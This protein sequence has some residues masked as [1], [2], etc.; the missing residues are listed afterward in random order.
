MWSIHRRAESLVTIT[1]YSYTQGAIT[2]T[3]PLL[4]QETLRRQL[5]NMLMHS[6]NEVSQAVAGAYL[7]TGSTASENG[8]CYRPNCFW[9]TPLAPVKPSSGGCLVDVSEGFVLLRNFLNLG[10]DEDGTTLEPLGVSC[11]P[12]RMC[13]RKVRDSKNPIAA[14]VVLQSILAELEW[15]SMPL[16]L[17]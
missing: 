4:Q 7:E 6:Q 14:A 16:M 9:S 2:L 15:S 13:L 11:N 17:S 1:T 10:P 5:V 12:A 8:N 3:L